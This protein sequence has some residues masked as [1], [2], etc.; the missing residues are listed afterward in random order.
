MCS[1]CNCICLYIHG[2]ILKFRADSV[3]LLT[4]LCLFIELVYFIIFI[5]LSVP[6]SVHP[7]ARDGRI[8][9][10]CFIII[11]ICIFNFIL[12]FIYLF[13][14]TVYSFNLSFILIEYL[15][16]SHYRCCS[17]F[18]FIIYFADYLFTLLFT[19]LLTY[20]FM[21]EPKSGSFTLQSGYPFAE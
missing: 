17:L 18:C 1:T 2:C 7:S 12:S 14:H 16:I 13:Y 21:L 19:T 8:S 11:I 6:L 9:Y 3:I 10:Y 20:S 15:F 5:L 4:C